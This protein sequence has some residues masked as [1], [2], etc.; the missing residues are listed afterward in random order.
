MEVNKH[1]DISDN[2][3]CEIGAHRKTEAPTKLTQY[4]PGAG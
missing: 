4:S 1:Q 3:A 2:E